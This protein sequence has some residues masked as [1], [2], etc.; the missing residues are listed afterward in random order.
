L[1]Y[2]DIIRGDPNYAHLALDPVEDFG[3]PSA[4]AVPANVNY[5]QSNL[6]GAKRTYTGFDFDIRKRFSEGHSLNVQYGYK[7]AMS[8]S[9]SDGN[10]DLQGDLYETDPRNPYMW[11][12]MPGTLSHQIK[13][14]GTYKTKVGLNISGLFYWNGG[15]D[16]TESWIFAPGSYDIY[17]NN[18]NSTWTDFAKTGALE[19]P[20][21]AQ[22]DLKFS[23]RWNFSEMANAQFFFDLYNLTDAQTGIVEEQGTNDPEFEFLELKKQLSPRRVY[24]GAR[25]NF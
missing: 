16:Y 18:P 17:I 22:L 21:W 10:A 23:Y 8:N 5:Y 13:L 6:V 12:S 1:L 15:W 9:Q 2:F 19:N 7:D 14:F 20:S 3:Y 25:I 11:G 24:M 4:D